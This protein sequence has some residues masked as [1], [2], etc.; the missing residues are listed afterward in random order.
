MISNYHTHTNYCDGKASPR[1]M[2]EYAVA[3]GMRYLGFSGHAP[4]PYENTFS[5]KDDNYVPYCNTIRELQ[6]EYAN[7]IEIR[8]GL[9]IDYVPGLLEDF[10]PL[11]EQGGLDYTIGSVHLIPN[12]NSIE[13]LRTHPQE[14][15]QHL[16]MI[17]GPH[18]EVYD[19]GLQ[20]HFGGDI[21]RAVKA[22]FHQTNTMIESQRPTIVGHFDKVVM[23][24]RDR[25]FHY[26]EPWFRNLMYETVELIHETGCICEINTRGLYKGRH[27]DYYPGRTTIRHMNEL[28][29]PV[30]VS[31]DA[32]APDD[33]IKS[34]C[35]EEFLRSIGY[36]EIVTRLS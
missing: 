24:N 27:N 14:A 5:I 34:E 29:I 13:E 30:I 36:K 9:E 28:G 25:Y 35:C 1:E 16:W 17:D 21:R 32:H 11:I 4:L 31:T 10:T 18:Y 6:H 15:A 20:R 12:P 8:L 7:Q 3:H 26:D 19:D 2:V 33:L 22:F 23:H